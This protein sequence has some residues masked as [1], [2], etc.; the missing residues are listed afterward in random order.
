MKLYDF[1][2]YAKRRDE[3]KAAQAVAEV[4]AA[5]L[6]QPGAVIELKVKVNY[7]FALHHEVLRQ[8]SS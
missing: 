4:V 6:N 3:R 1:S 8:A 2:F 7:W 5:D